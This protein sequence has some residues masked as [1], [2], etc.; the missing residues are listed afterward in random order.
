MSRTS[1]VAERTPL[2]CIGLLSRGSARTVE[3]RMHSTAFL[4]A[5]PPL[6]PVLLKR[7]VQ[8]C[9]FERS[10]ALSSCLVE[11]R[12]LE[13]RIPT[14]SFPASDGSW[15]SFAHLRARKLEPSGGQRRASTPGRFCPAFLASP[16]STS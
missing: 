8:F 2:L 14:S 12:R 5:R 11:P 3:P 6:A 4:P 10:C 16:D 1:D 13:S 15:P 9:S 7:L